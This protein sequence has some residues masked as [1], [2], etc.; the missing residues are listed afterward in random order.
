M[1]SCLAL[2]MVHLSRFSE[3]IVLWSSQEFRFVELDDAFSTGSSIMPQK[4]NPDVAELTR[5][6]SGRSIGGL[7]TLLTM[8]KGLP[9]AYNKDLQED[10]EAVFDLLDTVSMCL[11]AFTGMVR[12]LR[13]R[14][15]RMRAAAM[16]GFHQRHRS[17]RLS[18]WTRPSLPGRPRS[19]RPPGPP[20]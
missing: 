15:D 12:T 16:S 8:L 13:V 9:L 5:G 6:K 17:G 2:F 7:V 14:R 20:L 1:A 19:V 11:P 10:K 18:G 4:K 3:E